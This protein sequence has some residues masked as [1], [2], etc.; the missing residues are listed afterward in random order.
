M[1][2]NDTSFSD[3]CQGKVRVR[4]V[5]VRDVLDLNT[6]TWEDKHSK[7]SLGCEGQRAH[8]SLHHSTHCVATCN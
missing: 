2:Y 1:F 7:I 5:A 6:A 3:T 8:H 4:K